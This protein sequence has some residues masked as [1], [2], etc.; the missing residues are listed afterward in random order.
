MSLPYWV[1]YI[2]ILGLKAVVASQVQILPG[3]SERDAQSSHL[4]TV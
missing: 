1:K 2:Q 3:Y 4:A